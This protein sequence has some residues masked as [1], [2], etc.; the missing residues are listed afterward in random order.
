MKRIRKETQ[1]K[2]GP[3]ITINI[4]S[5]AIPIVGVIML[6]VGLFGGYYGRPASADVGEQAAVPQVNEPAPSEDTG[7]GNAE[8]MAF[9]VPQ[10]RHFKGDPDA[11]VTL[12]E[13]GDFQWPFCGRYATDAGRQIEETYLIDGKV[14]FAYVHFAFLGPESQWS[15]E[16]SECAA[17][18]DAFWEYHDLLYE[19]QNGENRDA[20]NQDNLKLFAGALGLDQETFDQCLDS[21]KYTELIQQET[22]MARQLGIQSTPSFLVNGT[23][24]IGAQPFQN[25]QQVIETMLAS[26]GTP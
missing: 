6:V 8:K 2:E 18:Q 16:A 14:R 13:F 25:F 26:E 1:P 24:I 3:A 5:W 12:V 23:Q 11:P 4:Q 15:A 21:G 22:E 20:F 9:L 19:N 7:V 10:I 17:D